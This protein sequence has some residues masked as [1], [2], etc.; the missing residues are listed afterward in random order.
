MNT[1]QLQ[2]IGHVPAKPASE[3]KVG[4][5]MI[6]NFGY[7][8]TVK[9]IVRQTAKSLWIKEVSDESGKT[10]ERRFLKS[11]LVGCKM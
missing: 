6:W 10:Y 9:E 3:L 1:I 8:S 5:V 4:D 11:R 7:T 2:A